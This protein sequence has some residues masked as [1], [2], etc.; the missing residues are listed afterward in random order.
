MEHARANPVGIPRKLVGQE[1]ILLEVLDATQDLCLAQVRVVEQL[2]DFSRG[3][4]VLELHAGMEVEA[5]LQVHTEQLET[6][7]V[8]TALCLGAPCA[9]LPLVPSHAILSLWFPPTANMFGSPYPAPP[10]MVLHPLF[11][12]K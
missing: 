3:L 2:E 5:R 1:Y 6:L 7:L 4:G 10:A 11:C 9:V 12:P 8:D